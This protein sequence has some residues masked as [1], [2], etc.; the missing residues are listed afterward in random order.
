MRTTTDVPVRSFVTRTLVPNARVLCAAVRSLVLKRSPLAVSLPWKPGPY[1]EALPL[2]TGLASSARVAEVVASAP[3]RATAA[4]A[5][6]FAAFRM[7]F[8]LLM[9]RCTILNVAAQWKA[10]AITSVHEPYTQASYHSRFTRPPCQ[11][12]KLGVTSRLGRVFCPTR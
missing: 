12:I 10:E 9:L 1:H 5:R 7:C 6:A 11:I 4:M 8:R 2:W 3:P